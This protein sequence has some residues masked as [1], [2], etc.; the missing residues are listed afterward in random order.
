MCKTMS[1][2]AREL[3]PF[4]PTGGKVAGPCAC[5]SNACS[6]GQTCESGRCIIKEEGRVCKNNVQK[7]ANVLEIWPVSETTSDRKGA[8]YHFAFDR[9]KAENYFKTSP[10][11]KY[12]QTYSGHTFVTSCGDRWNLDIFRKGTSCTANGAQMDCGKYS[13][14]PQDG[15]WTIQDSFTKRGERRWI[16]LEQ[17]LTAEELELAGV[18][19]S[20]SMSHFFMIAALLCL[21]GALGYYFARRQN[22]KANAYNVLPGK[23]DV[24]MMSAQ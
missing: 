23:N 17:F 4:C 10:K 22:N 12:G 21:S 3:L 11:W 7:P 16:A 5:G 9:T 6:K 14:N 15:D 2:W 1:K 13:T 19:E 24:E 8:G 20:S 18:A